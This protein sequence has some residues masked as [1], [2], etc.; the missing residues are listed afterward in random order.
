MVPR[1][2]N[3]LKYAFPQ[4]S[5]YWRSGPW[6]DT[7]VKFGVDPRTSRDY[8]IYQVVAFKMQAVKSVKAGKYVKGKKF[9]MLLSSTLA[10]FFMFVC[11]HDKSHIFDGKHLVEDGRI[12]QFCDI[13][14]PLVSALVKPEPG[15]MRETLDV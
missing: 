3:A 8:A 10:D 14:D 6:R 9:S 4:V 2:R 15:H 7:C 13:T 5:Y 11:R 12:Y 1:L